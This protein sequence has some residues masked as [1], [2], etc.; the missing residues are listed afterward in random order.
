M[1]IKITIENDEGEVLQTS[2]NN[3]VEMAVQELYRF[4]R[5][6]E[7]EAEK[8]QDAELDTI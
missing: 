2:E 3:S 6:E 4:E 8:L 1:V 5:N 7:N